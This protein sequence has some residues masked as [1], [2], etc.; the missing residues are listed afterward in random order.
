VDRAIKDLKAAKVLTV[1]QRRQLQED[2]SWKGLAAV[3]AVSKHLFGVFG[4]HKMLQYEQKKAV[5]RLKRKAQEW[6]ANDGQ[7][8]TL[9]GISKYALVVSGLKTNPLQKAKNRPARASKSPPKQD[10]SSSIDQRMANIK[11]AIENRSR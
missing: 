9:T 2:G 5:N 7:K 11:Q 3:K 1:A 4:L 10:Y 8:R 6:S